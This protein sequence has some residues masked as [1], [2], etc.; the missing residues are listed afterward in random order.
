[1]ATS[2]IQSEALYS[3]AQVREL[4]KAALA[5]SEIASIDL[6]RRA[7]KAAYEFLRQRWPAARRI[8]VLCGSGNNGGDGYAL[9]TLA[10]KDQLEVDLIVLAPPRPGSEAALAYAEWTLT[11][12]KVLANTIWPEADVYVDALFGI[13]LARALEPQAETWIERLNSSSKPVLARSEER[14]VGKEC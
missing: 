4:E 14:R 11:G 8:A 5:V 2:P 3:V 13:G 9:A 1:M 10:R 7:A 12:G 6:M